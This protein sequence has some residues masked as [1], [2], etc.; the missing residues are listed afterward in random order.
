[1]FSFLGRSFALVVATLHLF[2]KEREKFGEVPWLKNEN[3]DITFHYLLSPFP[4]ENRGQL[5][6]IFL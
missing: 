1:M 5:G 4:P 2:E 6:G 3:Y